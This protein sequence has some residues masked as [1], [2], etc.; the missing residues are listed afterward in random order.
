M[1][2]RGSYFNEKKMMVHGEREDLT[3]EG[4]VLATNT[5]NMVDEI[6]PFK[7]EFY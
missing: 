4:H 1:L 7:D 5:K 2:S 6:L 3:D